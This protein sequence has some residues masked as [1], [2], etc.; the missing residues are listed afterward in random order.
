MGYLSKYKEWLEND[1][2]DDETKKE[3]FGIKDN[4]LEIK[5]RFYS[6]L[7]FGTAGLRG[8]LGAGTNRMNKYTVALA[9]QGLSNVILNEGNGAKE[10]G[11]VIA[12]D[13]R[14]KSDEFANIAA[15]VLTAN[16]I[17]V[18]L[19]DDIR[20]TPLLAYSVR[21]LNTQAGIIVTASHNPREYNG[22]KVYWEDGS[23]IL[24][25]VA[26]DILLEIEKIGKFEN[27]KYKDLNEAKEEGLL[28]ILDDTIDK[29]YLN[30]RL[31]E[32]I[33]DDV[34]KDIKIVYTPLNGVGNKPVREILKRRGF[35]NVFVVKE[36][37]NPDPNFTT[38]GY[39]NP[40]DIN[41]FDLS[42]K[43]AKEIDADFII[44][45]D[46]DSDRLS[47]V[48]KHE[49]EYV[50]FTGNEIGILLVN[51]ILSVRN[52]KGDLPKNGAIVKSIVTGDMTKE[53]AKKYG[54]KTFETLTGFKNIC[55]K[56]NEWEVTKEYEYIFGFEESIGYTYGDLVRDKDAIVTAML[57]AEMAG[58]YKKH[59][60][61]LTNVLHELYEEFGYYKEDLFSI[62]L[63]GI[64]GM[65]RI[66]R[67]MDSFREKGISQVNDLYLDKIIDYLNENTGNPKSN[68]LKYYYHEGSWFAIRPSGTEPKLKIYIY[69]NDESE[70]VAQEKINN[71][72][73]SILK[74]IDMIK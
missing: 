8:K 30:I 65:E 20:S 11:V 74:K 37:E 39:P 5:D 56:A 19:F 1:I 27:I 61:T 26:N 29:E 4:D 60:K 7:R 13:V 53:I 43:L 40:E 64:E 71:L 51:Y 21:R 35:K 69:S 18:Y 25:K 38:V 63:D 72:K 32:K 41:A 33:T 42:I 9:T 70:E 46:P 49:G 55:S 14:K 12:Y 23:Q 67:I 10:K 62:V 57:S 31:S 47:F 24:D 48:E 28:E 58:Y 45:T 68:V 22:Y 17:K 2:F 16:G 73:E 36:Q 3:L 6:D 54:V 66:T 15:S 50:Y 59:N 52:E 44:A 34:D